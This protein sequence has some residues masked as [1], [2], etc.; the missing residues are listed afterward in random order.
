[1]S[2]NRGCGCWK[3]GGVGCAA[4]FIL[5]VLAAVLV[6]LNFDRI[7]ESEWG[8][9]ITAVAEDA[10]ESFA[11]MMALR[12]EIV[13]SFAM[14]NCEVNLNTT[15]SQ[16]AATRSLQLTLVNAVV[17]EGQDPEEY[18]RQVARF[19]AERF[20]AIE[21]LDQVVIAVQRKVGSGIRLSGSRS[22]RFPV[23]DLLASL[24]AEA[25]PSPD[26]VEAPPSEA[27]G[28]IE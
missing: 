12:S 24:P 27:A 20:A 26:E 15:R 23:A 8:R 28:E 6:G 19:A 4:L 7:K 10:Q 11:D 18:A 1:M 16:G 17:P 9:K 21:E 5:A 2:K 13:G 3:L 25:G 22:F 14:E